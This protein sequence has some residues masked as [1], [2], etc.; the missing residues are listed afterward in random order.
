MF[1]YLFHWTWPFLAIISISTVTS[2][3][4]PHRTSSSNWA[5]IAEPASNFFSRLQ[6]E[7]QFSQKLTCSSKLT[8]HLIHPH[9][10]PHS[11]H[12]HLPTGSWQAFCSRHGRVWK[13]SPGQ[14][15]FGVAC[16]PNSTCRF[17][18]CI[19]TG[20]IGLIPGRI[21]GPIGPWPSDA[22]T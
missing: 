16:I 7:F 8:L 1:A 12:S 5:S 9:H 22:V 13:V 6:N 21:F 4:W 2:R 3:I 10:S 17:P 11:D 14:W 20:T 15:H 19:S 18:L